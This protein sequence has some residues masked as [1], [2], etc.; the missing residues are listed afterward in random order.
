M[1]K[2]LTISVAAYNAAPFIRQALESM[3]VPDMMDCFEVFVVDDG[4]KDGTF[5]IAEEYA[6]QYP[7][8]F[9]PVHKENGGYGSVQNWSIA[10]AKGKYFK[11][12]DGDDWFQRDEFRRLLDDLQKSD[13][14][15]LVNH[16][17]KVIEGSQKT[18]EVNHQQKAQKM[19][20]QEYRGTPIF[21]HWALTVKTELLKG[22]ECVLPEHCLYTD[23]ILCV[24]PFFHA[25]TIQF[26][27]YSVY[28][29]RLG[30]EGQS[31]S[32]EAKIKHVAEEMKVIYLVCENYE[33]ALASGQTNPYV[34]R[35][36]YRYYVNALKTVLLMPI[37]RENYRR[38]VELEKLTKEKYPHVYH[39]AVHAQKSG[40]ILWIL[41]A[42]RYQAYWLIKLLP[43]GIPNWS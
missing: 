10:H 30:R 17:T 28:Q 14:D 35:R 27:D 29:Y 24:V 26:L 40:K 6:K 8:T 33:K 25:A 42:S 15:I 2:I 1:E 7:E 38:M 16:F 34:A 43:N 37:T 20:I 39:G 19:R 23:Q 5:A 31:I 18:I 12:L 32:R 9:I 4:S 3:I 41:R 21:G 11:L 22:P 36:V 13:A